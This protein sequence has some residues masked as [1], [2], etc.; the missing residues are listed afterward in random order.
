MKLDNIL[1]GIGIQKVDF[2]KIDVEEAEVE[3]LEG[4]QQIISN[5]NSLKILV[6]CSDK[7]LGRTSEILGNHGIVIKSIWRNAIYGEKGS[8]S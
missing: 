2:I 8:T 6:S 5:S 1:N 4:A 7:S 3:V